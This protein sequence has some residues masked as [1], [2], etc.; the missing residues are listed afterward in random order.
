MSLECQVYGQPTPEVRL[1]RLNA[2]G[3]TLLTPGEQYTVWQNVT[4]DP[5]GPGDMKAH[6]D[7]HQ[8]ARDLM[9]SAYRCAAANMMGEADD[10]YTAGYYNYRH[11]IDDTISYSEW[12]NQEP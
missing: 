7:V 6:V 4:E 12:R 5:W 8:P 1:Y 10:T 11:Y 3:Q 9:H 2:G